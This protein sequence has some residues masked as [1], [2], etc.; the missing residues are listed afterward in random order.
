M[1]LR[2]A[3]LACAL[4]VLVAGLGPSAASAAP[5]HN[6]GLT[7][8]A[9][10]HSIIAGESV[11]IHGRLTGPNP[12]GQAIRLYHRINPQPGFSLI[13]VTKT[14]SAGLYE[15]TREEGVVNTNRS[16]YVRGPGLT[17][18]H[19]VHERVAALVSLAAS[20]TSGD[21]RHPIVFSGHV[22]PDHAGN[23]VL[24]QVNTG[25]GD[26]WRT[27]KSGRIGPG[28]NYQIPAGFRTPGERDVRVVLPGDAR[29]IRT[30]SDPVSV[31][32]QQ[33]EHADFTIHTTS[34]I[35]SNT[36]PYTIS[37][38]LDQPGTTTPEPNTSVSLFARDP[39]T[40]A[41][42][43]VTTTMTDASGAY[44]FANLTSTTNELYQ[45]RTTFGPAR[46]DSAVLFQGVQDVLNMSS[47]SSTSTVGGKVTFTGSVAP[48]K[49]GHVIYLQRL[50]ADGDWHTVEVR[51]VVPGSTFTFGWTFGT[52]G[53][54]QFRARILGGPENVG[55]ASSA[56]TV[57]VTQLPVAALPASS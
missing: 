4:S 44:S 38:T 41:Y 54:K 10:P 47:S 39:G 17:H 56:V 27:I 55:A 19:T 45:A 34:P 36:A 22:T 14:D 8:R 9:V 51:T 32:I 5:H 42:H 50:G 11:L 52:A 29:N 20:T 12:A 21:T 26:E 23:R 15:F 1:R 37:G 33:T 25:R 28:S 46:D 30:A 49:A 48:D 2:I 57:V 13:G 31:I 53:T 3:M 40:P 43:V 24:L 6:R 18:S 7:L 16:W 35:V